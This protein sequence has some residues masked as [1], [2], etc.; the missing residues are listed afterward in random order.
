MPRRRKPPSQSWRTFLKNHLGSTV[1]VDFFAVPTPTC[2][3][4]FVFVVLAHDR[5]RIL[6]VNV[7]PQPSSAWTRQQLR[8]SFTDDATARFLLHDGDATFDAAFSRTA[9][10]LGLTSVRTAPRSPRQRRR[11]TGPTGAPT[12]GRN[13]SPRMLLPGTSVGPYEIVDA[14]GRGGMGEVYRARDTRLHRQVAIKILPSGGAM[15][16]Q[17]RERFDREAR[18]VAALSHPNIVAIYDVGTHDGAPYAAIELLEGDTLRSRIG[19]SPLPLRIVLD[20]GVQIARGLAAAHGRGIVHRDLKPDN[21]FVTR[22]GQ[23]KIL[24]FGIA[25]EPVTATADEITRVGQTE[26]GTVLGTVGYMSPEQA[27]GERAD[28]RSDIFSFGCVLYEMVS[29]RRAFTG[30]SRIETLHAILK[31][32]PPNLAAA[33]HDIP[34]ALDRLIMR[35]L[36]KAPERRFQTALDLVFALENQTNEFGR[37][38][39]APFPTQPRD[40]RRWAAAA[41][42]AAAVAGTGAVWWVANRE[43]PPNAPIQAVAASDDSRRL[44]AVLPFQ[45]ISREGGPG[46][47][48]AG[49][50]EEVTNQLSKL[51]AL[52]VVGRTAV[53]KFKDARTDLPA[54]VQELGIG[55]VVT[56]TVREDGSRVRVNVE[57]M[58]A[59]SR[60]QIWSEQ[61]DREGVHVFEAQSDIA[62]RVAEALRASVTLEEQSRIGR[63]PTGSVA[64]YELFVRGRA[65]TRANRATLTESIDILKQAVALDPQFALALTE[66]AMRYQFLGLFGD[67]SAAAK[68]VDAA[69]RALAIDSQLAQAHHAL[70]V[71]TFQTGHLQE[72]LAAFHKAVAL[73]PNYGYA[74]NDYGVTLN[75]A[76]RFDEALHWAKRSLQLTPNQ[77]TPYYHVGLHLLSLDDDSRT[78]RF[79]TAAA[80]RFPSSV[81]LQILLAFLDLRRG[82][83]DAALDRIRRTVD[84]TPRDV[85]GLLARSEIATLVGSPEAERFTQPLLAESADAPTQL[86]SHNLRLLY[87]Y[88]LHRRGQKVGAATAMNQIV[89][90]SEEAIR[91]GADWLMWP[92][93]NVTV[94]AMRGDTPAALD[95]LERAYHAGWRDARTTRLLPMW[96]SLRRELRFER[97][98]VQIEADVAAMRERADYS[99]LP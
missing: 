53:A 56:G 41:A 76:G 23:V 91:G 4:L 54:M 34:T 11:L 94:H 20:Y 97:L 33:V 39:A 65:M 73:D 83:A 93:Q 82:R 85:E 68:S 72:A 32:R 60:R 43:R 35:C 77:S 10:A 87:A 90:A 75:A 52:R 88:L 78:E 17:F 63:R 69:H 79:L 95:W 42:V 64:A 26:V 24:D 59:R 58:D 48:A 9:E 62:L 61:Y 71:G 31:E 16:P 3:L 45:N 92:I 99:G 98:V 44:L 74:L 28:E 47:F 49:M 25:T 29:A 2:R 18:A 37:P 96:A 86:I 21:V 66:L 5:R 30:D 55:S 38:T 6:R 1:A 80:T 8:E 57:L 50:T 81:R 70:G 89:A 51:S 19:T 7:A 27:R 13:R 36:E 14:I 22:D 40:V 12:I 67:T 46:Y 15:D 84:K